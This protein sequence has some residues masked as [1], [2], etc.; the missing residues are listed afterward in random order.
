VLFRP[1]NHISHLKDYYRGFDRSIIQRRH[2]CAMFD[3]ALAYRLRPGTCTVSNR[4]STVEYTINRAGLRDSDDKLVDPEV[5][6]LGDSIAMGWGVPS[7]ATLAQRLGVLTGRSVLNAAISSYETVREMK[8]L[9]ELIQPGT[10]YIVIAYCDNDYSGNWTFTRNGSL[11]RRDRATYQKTV[12]NHESSA[13]YYPFKHVWNL[14]RSV[15]RSASADRPAPALQQ[16]PGFAAM[17]FLAVLESHRDL[18]RGR[19]LIVFEANS[20]NQNSSLFATS[21]RKAAARTPLLNALSSMHVVDTS[22]FLTD[23][24]YFL[25]DDHMR[26]SGHDKIARVLTKITEGESGWRVQPAADRVVP[27]H[28]DATNGHIE[29]VEQ[30]GALTIISGWAARS[31]TGEP[32]AAVALLRDGTKVVEAE[33]VL[34]RND[35]V[36]ALRK[37][38]AA[39]SG[40][41]LAVRTGLLTDSKGLQVVGIWRDGSNGPLHDQQRLRGN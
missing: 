13:R 4:E 16:K 12:S 36:A 37:P 23:D 20:Y 40:Y 6:V 17:T 34:L 3:D 31:D 26:A 22:T 10:Q 19:H 24:D 8:L 41:A 32:A 33:P 15:L 27:H 28:T 14:G 11:P 30:K 1:A 29:R 38:S 18:L 7:D 35:V 21:L 9:G 2:D 25:L 39:R 5:I